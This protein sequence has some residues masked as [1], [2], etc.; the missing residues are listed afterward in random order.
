M[1]ALFLAN[2]LPHSRLGIIASRRLGGAVQRNRAKRLI[3][4]VFR[5]NK[6][7]GSGWDLVIIPK[8]DLLDADYTAI[9]ADFRNICQRHARRAG[10]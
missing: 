5:L 3:R 8:T 7:A 9:E 4:E 10:V 2:G 1:T 6:P